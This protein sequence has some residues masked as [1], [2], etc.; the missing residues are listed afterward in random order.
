MEGVF[1]ILRLGV[2]ILKKKLAETVS[3]MCAGENL[4]SYFHSRELV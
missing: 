4:L 3:F 1:W 2:F